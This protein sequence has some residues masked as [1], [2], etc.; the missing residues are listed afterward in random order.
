M[1]HFFICLFIFASFISIVTCIKGQYLINKLVGIRKNVKIFLLRIFNHK[2][3]KILRYVSRENVHM[4]SVHFSFLLWKLIRHNL[5]WMISFTYSLTLPTVMTHLT[6]QIWYN[7]ALDNYGQAISKSYLAQSCKNC[8]IKLVF[9][10]ARAWITSLGTF[11]VYQAWVYAA[12][13]Q[14]CP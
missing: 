2:Q 4:S 3:P 10:I 9:D 1:S 6:Q 11:A 8:W 7:Q 5:L 12:N 14:Q 13:M